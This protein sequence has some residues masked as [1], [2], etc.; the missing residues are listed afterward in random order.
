MTPVPLVSERG[1]ADPVPVARSSA[2]V[3]E[4]RDA[5]ARSLQVACCASDPAGDAANRLVPSEA[6]SSAARSQ[7]TTRPAPIMSL[8]QPSGQGARPSARH[9]PLP[10]DTTRATT[11]YTTPAVA[12]LPAGTP[13]ASALPPLA[14]RRSATGPPASTSA[15]PSP[16]RDAAREPGP[17]ARSATPKAPS[18]PQARL[19]ARPRLAGASTSVLAP[20]PRPLEPRP[21]PVGILPA[22]TRRAEAPAAAGSRAQ[23]QSTAVLEKSPRLTGSTETRARGTTL[24]GAMTAAPA[25]SIDS[26]SLS[27]ARV[28]QANGAAPETAVAPEQI[29]GHVLAILA[30]PSKGPDGVWTTTIRLDPP[31]LGTVEATVTVRGSEVAVVLSYQSDTTHRALQAALH[32]IESNIGARATVTLADARSGSAGT[33]SRGQ[34]DQKGLS[35]T[36][37]GRS[38]RESGTRSGPGQ[39]FSSSSTRHGQVD[40]LA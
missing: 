4:A 16:T 29:D 24:S 37:V 11:P 38:S 39:R 36:L 34:G 21:A 14:A 27:L 26:P 1:R 13:A 3:T 12:V 8:A 19:A 18:D 25:S 40:V 30:P 9:S 17:V 5:F 15:R 28:P 2:P 10:S 32:T 22:V 31:H 23:G 20:E 33:S 7:S 6:P 35:G